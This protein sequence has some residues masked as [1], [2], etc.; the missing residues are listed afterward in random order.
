MNEKL[1]NEYISTCSIILISNMDS[2]DEYLHPLNIFDIFSCIAQQ[3]NNVKRMC[4]LFEINQITA[5]FRSQFVFTHKVKI[6]RRMPNVRLANV[7]T[8]TTTIIHYDD[9][10]YMT[11]YPF[12]KF[13]ANRL[14][15]HLIRLELYLD[16]LNIKLFKY[17]EQS[18]TLQELK[19][20]FHFQTN[21]ILKI[22]DSVKYLRLKGQGQVQLNANLETLNISQFVSSSLMW[23]HTFSNLHTL[24]LSEHVKHM[25]LHVMPNL[26]R[27]HLYK[28]SN[29][30]Q[31]NIIPTS[32]NTIVV[33]HYDVELIMPSHVEKLIIHILSQS[34]RQIKSQLEYV[35]IDNILVDVFNSDE[36]FSLPSTI[37]TFKSQN[38]IALPFKNYDNLQHLELCMVDKIEL[39]LDY[40]IDI[41]PRLEYLW[42]SHCR[43]IL[44]DQSSA[45]KYLRVHR[46]N[47]HAKTFRSS[48]LQTLH[49]NKCTL[50]DFTE[51]LPS[52]LKCLIIDQCDYDIEQIILPS[53]THL[54]YVQFENEIVSIAIFKTLIMT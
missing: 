29:F 39:I 8:Y 36:L 23:N 25:P 21:E 12:Y 22:P 18:Q 41:M 49:V 10:K 51:I 11:I 47:E 50:N 34:F 40:D 37:K 38:M 52:S 44:N 35:A 53:L 4:I 20:N 6:N 54:K 26:T 15:C 1:K 32:V 43:M 14:P 42:I 24:I 30:L 33:R 19:I 17:I 5:S 27:M 9:I 45:L 48:Q 3:F 2:L 16:S 13:K 28:L 46:L 7:K 31:T